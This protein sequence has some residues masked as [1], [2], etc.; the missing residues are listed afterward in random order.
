MDASNLNTRQKAIIAEME[1]EIDKVIAES[2]QAVELAKGFGEAV[3]VLNA[4]NQNTWEEIRDGLTLI[5]KMVNATLAV[6][7]ADTNNN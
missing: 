7:A 6:S 5:L 3:R 4:L 1:A 2:P